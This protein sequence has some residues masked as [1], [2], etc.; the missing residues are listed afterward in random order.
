MTNLLIG[1]P[2]YADGADVSASEAFDSRYSL[3]NLI[4]GGRSRLGILD[5]AADSV[6]ITVDAGSAS[7]TIDFF[8]VARANILKAQG[9]TRLKLSGDISGDIAGTDVDLQSLDLYGH[10]DQDAIFTSELNNSDVGGLSDTSTNE[11]YDIVIGQAGVD[12]EVCWG[13]SKFMFGEWFDFGRDPENR[14]IEEVWKKGGRDPY[15]EITFIWRGISKE[16]KDSAISTIIENRERGCILYTRDYHA[17]LLS[18]RVMHS[19]VER[20]ET[21]YLSDQQYDM[22]ITFREQI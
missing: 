2:A 15:L 17:P 16:K 11:S 13:F 18:R 21:N 20:Y 8:Y 14:S 22:S 3:E 10:G 7:R 1:V 4:A 6:T 19:F 5:A 12:D 9:A